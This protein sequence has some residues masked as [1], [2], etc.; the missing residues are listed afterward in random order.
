MGNVCFGRR[1]ELSGSYTIDWDD[2][3]SV[4]Y[5]S[6]LNRNFN[7]VIS[8]EDDKQQHHSA[9]S[10]TFPNQLNESFIISYSDVFTNTHFT[11]HHLHPILRK[12]I[13]DKKSFIN[14]ISQPYYI[15]SLDDSISSI[16]STKKEEI[17][18]DSHTP[19][20]G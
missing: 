7:R 13:R 20:G 6:D 3:I 1:R 9:T 11:P 8:S 14:F 5:F 2:S 12:P 17:Q 19:S 4:N 18:N 16:R 15:E 10:V